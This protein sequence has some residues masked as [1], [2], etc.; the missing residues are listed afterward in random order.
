MNSSKEY[1]PKTKQKT[2]ETAIRLLFEETEAGE[3]GMPER[4][5]RAIL[6][7]WKTCKSEKSWENQLKKNDEGHL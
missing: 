1:E 4:Q 3:K 6:A 7:P 5:V 2:L